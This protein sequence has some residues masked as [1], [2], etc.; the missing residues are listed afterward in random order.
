MGQGVLRTG[1]VHDE[2][3]RSVERRNECQLATGGWMVV[4]SEA[5]RAPLPAAHCSLLNTALLL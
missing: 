1:R 3:V 5:R 2:W 4:R